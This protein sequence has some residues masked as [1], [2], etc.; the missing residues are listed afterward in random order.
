MV[1]D[2][3]RRQDFTP[4]VY[5]TDDCGKTWKSL[6]TAD[7]R[8]YA[9]SIEQDPAD[10]DLLFLGTEFGLYASID[11]GARW[12]P[13]TH[14]VPTT[15]VMALAIHPREL[16]LVIGTHGRA[17]YVLDDIRPLRTLSEKTLAE[18]VHLYETGP[19]QQH[20]NA[21]E[22]GGF[23]FGSGEFR[24]EN[25]PY[26]A[27]LTF[28]LNGPGLPYPDDK[29]ERERKAGEW[30]AR[31]KAEQAKPVEGLPQTARELHASETP[32]KPVPGSRARR[33]TK[34]SPPRSRSASP[35]PAARRSAPS[36]PRPGKG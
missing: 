30:E 29:K 11:G 1:F 26:G 17:L 28:S 20:W 21:A 16:D 6:A 14:G 35:T 8:G 5:R 33:R 19:A 34:G 22:P 36:P 15:S 32:G 23:A 9:L 18:P 25:E 7:L 2:N 13:W 31:L 24:G 27:I 3:H 10:K 12:M 4:Y